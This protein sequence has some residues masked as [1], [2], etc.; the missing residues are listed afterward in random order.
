VGEKLAMEFWS[1]TGQGN[2]RALRRLCATG[3]PAAAV[4]R[5][6]G[7]AGP[8]VA[9]GLAGER[10]ERLTSQSAVY[11]DGE[12]AGTSGDVS[13]SRADYTY[14]LRWHPQTRLI[15]EVLPFG[16]WVSARMPSPRW[17]FTPAAARMFGGLP[18]PD[19]DLDPV[20]IR[21]WRKA[22]ATHGLPLTLRCLAAWW[23]IDDDAGLL[24]AYQ[25]S[26]LAAAIHRMIG[27]RAAEPGTT[28]DAIADLYRV[29]PADTRAVTPLLQ[30]RLKLSPAQPW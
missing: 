26:V 18:E 10:P 19:M 20:A 17:L 24:A 7:A 9:V 2:L 11:G 22:L 3:T 4:I 27:Y 8:A 16:S 6:Y 12:L 1:V 30:T 14:L 29:A 28:H 5:L 23:R 21:L 15:C 25:P 13:T